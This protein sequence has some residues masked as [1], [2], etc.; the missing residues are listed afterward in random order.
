A[1]WGGRLCLFGHGVGGRTFGRFVGFSFG[2]TIH[3]RRPLEIASGYIGFAQYLN[4]LWPGVTTKHGLS[5][6]GSVIVIGLGMLCIALLYRRI[7]S[8]GKITVGLWIGTLLTT[9]AVILTG[10][11][12]FN[13]KL[14]FDFPPEEVKFSLGFLF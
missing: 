14:A 13:P 3:P 1:G 11:L 9:G 4:Y 2:R 12:H 7:T 10:A 5:L 8:I 6:A